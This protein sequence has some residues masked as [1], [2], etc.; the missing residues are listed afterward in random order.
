MARDAPRRRA[1]LSVARSV[2]R[3]VPAARG[4]STAARPRRVP[5]PRGR[6]AYAG[7][8]PSPRRPVRATARRP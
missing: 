8:A 4:G 1:T 3:R 2:H 5:S 7:I 6:P